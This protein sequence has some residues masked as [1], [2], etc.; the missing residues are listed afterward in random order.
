MA[1]IT[2]FAP[3]MTMATTQLTREAARAVVA[4]VRFEGSRAADAP[5]MNW[6]VVTD[7]NGRRRLRMNW[8]ADQS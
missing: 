6:V 4:R 2:M 8:A 1:S 5:R 3:P 7:K